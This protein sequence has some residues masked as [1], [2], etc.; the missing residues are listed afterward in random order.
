MPPILQ[1][2]YQACNAHFPLHPFSKSSPTF[3]LDEP[4]K[5]MC[6]FRVQISVL[7]L[8]THLA[9]PLAKDILRPK[10]TRLQL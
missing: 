1:L 3:F 7:S 10:K 4:S 2:S 9:F 6:S 5:K 8:K